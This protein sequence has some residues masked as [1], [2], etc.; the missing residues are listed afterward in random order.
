MLL[1]FSAEDSCSVKSVQYFA[2]RQWLKVYFLVVMSSVISHFLYKL[3]KNSGWQGILWAAT[4][5]SSGH[6]F[7][8]LLLAVTNLTQGSL[9]EVSWHCP[10]SNS[11]SYSVVSTKGEGRLLMFQG[12]GKNHHYE[13]YLLHACS[14][15]YRTKSSIKAVWLQNGSGLFF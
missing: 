15:R 1:N 6:H 12:A 8:K 7:W 11:F 2:S 9:A 10:S 14:Q 4:P 13:L 3:Y 5:I